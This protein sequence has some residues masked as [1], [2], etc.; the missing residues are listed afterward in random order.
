MMIRSTLLVVLL[1]AGALAAE[2]LKS[3]PQ[4]GQRTGAFLPL[5]LNGPLAGQEQC[6]V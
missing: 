6:P 5:F 3:G 4:V 1:A 2:D